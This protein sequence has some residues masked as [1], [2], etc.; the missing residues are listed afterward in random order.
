MKKHAGFE[1]AFA[2]T[3]VE[4]LTAKA[5]WLIM[6]MTQDPMKLNH[7]LGKLSNGQLLLLLKLLRKILADAASGTDLD[8]DIDAL[9][10]MANYA[11]T[12]TAALNIKIF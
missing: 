6:V 11:F 1:Y 4:N 8:D 5:I 9:L 2:Y 12:D 3:G 10:I 7:L